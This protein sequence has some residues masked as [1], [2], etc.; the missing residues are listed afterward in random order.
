MATNAGKSVKKGG[1]GKNTIAQRAGGKVTR[2][3][4]T[5]VGK[6]VKGGTSGGPGGS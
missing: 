5:N 4:G 3:K 6:Q 1:R 2:G